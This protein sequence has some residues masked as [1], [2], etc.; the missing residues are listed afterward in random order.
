MNVQSFRKSGDCKLTLYHHNGT[1]GIAP[2]TSPKPARAHSCGSTLRAIVFGE[3][4]EAI[5][6]MSCFMCLDGWQGMLFCELARRKWLVT[7]RAVQEP[8]WWT[9]TM[10]YLFV[11]DTISCYLSFNDTK[12]LTLEGNSQVHILKTAS[13]AGIQGPQSFSKSKTLSGWCYCGLCFGTASSPLVKISIWQIS[14]E[15]SAHTSLSKS[16]FI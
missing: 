10:E 15:H 8:I 16:E 1:L 14:A 4:S 6:R 9:K 2:E 5:D 7:R 13:N 12:N 11:F 3:S